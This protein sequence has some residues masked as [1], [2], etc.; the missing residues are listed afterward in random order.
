MRERAPRLVPWALCLLASSGCLVSSLHPVYEDDS[1]VFDEMLLGGWENR[2]SEI[3]VAVSRGE[4]RS[5]Q[6]AFTDRFG[7]TRFNGHLTTVGVARFLNVLPHEGL[8]QP[9]FVVVTNGFFQIDIQSSQVRVREP[10][11]AAVL[12]R[13]RSGKLGV[14]AAIDVK[15][16]VLLTPSS[17][18]LRKWLG[19]ALKDDP[20]WADW[21]TFTRT[22]R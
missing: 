5:Y 8:E 6:I 15:Q 3:K 1:I 9:P 11:Y 20:L 17:A 2:E 10:D 4:W 19:T 13:A 21:K 18:V 7:T 22:A 12:E 16:N 14:D